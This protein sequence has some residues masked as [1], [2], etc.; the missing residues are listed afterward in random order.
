MPRS[1]SD[2]VFK[3]LATRGEENLKCS[4][5]QQLRRPFE[6]VPFAKL[7]T[8]TAES[9]W[10]PRQTC[11]PPFNLHTDASSE[12]PACDRRP[13]VSVPP[14]G[15]DWKIFVPTCDERCAGGERDAN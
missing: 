13:R 12:P 2:K 6:V 11:H 14:V 3:L 1:S 4:S 10:C 7:H 8:N 9:F 5:R 15:R